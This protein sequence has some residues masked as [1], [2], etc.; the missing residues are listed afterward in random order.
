MNSP[1][2]ILT[3]VATALLVAIALVRGASSERR[4]P[5]VLLRNGHVL[6]G[7]P[8]NLGDRYVITLEDGGE[9]R[10]PAKQVVIACESIDEAYQHLAQGLTDRRRAG[11]HLELAKWCVR[12]KLFAR[13]VEQL[14]I[15]EHLDARP[16]ELDPV[17]RQLDHAQQLA[18]Q[19]DE[20]A[21][22]R[23]IPARA[24]SAAQP[25]RAA[26]SPEQLESTMRA[27]PKDSVHMFTNA[28]QPLLLN[29]CT[30]GRCHDANSQSN[31]SLLRP[32]AGTQIWRRLT[33]RNLHGVIQHVDR[34]QPQNSPLLT[35][36][37]E[38]HGGTGD[39]PLS[40]Q[41]AAY[42]QLYEWVHRAAGSPPKHGSVRLASAEE[43]IRKGS[44]PDEPPGDTRSF[45]T[46]SEL[47]EPSLLRPG[48]VKPVESASDGA[49]TDEL[50]ESD[51][52]DRSGF[53]PRDPFDPEIFN[54]QLRRR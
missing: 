12:Q 30:G 39:S 7:E 47:T 11:P 35:M 9:V 38:P 37:R 8:T 23:P 31:L 28:V 6:Y 32:T 54:R 5:L 20:H 13:A 52:R 44:E 15:A 18:R 51:D 19:S 49:V 45:E 46:T 10:V 3:F 41:S 16:A 26:V 42:A 22:R 17:R 36:A 50:T 34:V 4:G 24:V 53:R 40:D 25:A 21:E 2:R 1:T 14:A 27:L 43:P 48:D 33:L 29:R